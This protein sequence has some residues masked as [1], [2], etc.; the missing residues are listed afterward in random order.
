MSLRSH[1]IELSILREGE[2]VLHNCTS[3]WLIH[4]RLPLLFLITILLPFM[5]I[6]FMIGAGLISD[7]AVQNLIWFLFCLYGLLTTSYFFLR[8]VNFELGGCVITNQR[9]LR[10]GYTGLSTMVE[11]EILPNKIEDVKVEKRGLLSMVS[12][13][14]YV[15]IHTS[16]NSVEVLRNVIQARKIQE[17]FSDLLRNFGKKPEDKPAAPT[18]S[19]AEAW[20]DDAL[21]Q[22]EGEEFDVEEHRG[23]TIGKIGEVFRGPKD[24]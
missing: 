8:T 7:P 21:G 24:H 13:T 2:R 11:R 14:A 22:T 17:V 4:L 16:N 12:D 19:S 5:A 20:I 3:H 15:S 10:F 9:V 18:S 23:K 1:Q 6:F